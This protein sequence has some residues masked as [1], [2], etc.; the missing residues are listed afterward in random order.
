[1]NESDEKLFER[2]LQGD[3]RPLRTLMERHGD[4]LMLFLNGYVRDLVAAEDLMIES[5]SRM[6]VKRPSLRAGG[7]KPYLYK[8]GRNLAL[9]RMRERSRVFSLDDLELDP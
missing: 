3:D 4:A 8:V 5:F 6:Y 7:F 1:M 9:H 2:S